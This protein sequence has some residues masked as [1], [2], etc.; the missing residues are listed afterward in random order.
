MSDTTLNGQTALVTGA[1]AGIGRAVALQLAALG[2]DIVLHGRDDQR[3]AAVV[4][5]IQAL[6]RTARF[7]SA[8]LTEAEDTLRLAA[9]AGVIDILVN[10]AGIYSFLSTPDADAAT[11]D[12]HFAIN[13]RAPFLLVGALAPAMAGRGHGSIINVTS[14]AATSPSPIGAAYGASKAAVELLTKSWATEFAAQGLRVNA[15]SPGPVRTAGTESMLGEHIEM[16]GRGNLRGTVGEPEEIAQV[17]A[18]LA[19][20][21]SSY[22]NGSVFLADGGALSAMPS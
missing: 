6:S 9:E 22:V 5:A 19:S 21:A 4:S 8:D 11:F 20:P 15:V 18:F 3:G 13:T 2:A 12:R 10:N 17:V 16:L 1:T 14:S 7:I